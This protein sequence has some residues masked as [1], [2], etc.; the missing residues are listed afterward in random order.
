MNKL[1]LLCV[2]ISVFMLTGCD[3]FRTLAG[4]PTS[5][6]I[7]AKQEVLREEQRQARDLAAKTGFS[8]V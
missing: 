7:E 5:K 6:D 1:T 2:V 8:G 4:R 3:F